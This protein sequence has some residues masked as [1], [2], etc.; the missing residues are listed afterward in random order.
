MADGPPPK[1]PA[2][3]SPA[4][5]LVSWASRAAILS[6]AAAFTMPNP[7]SVLYP[8]CGRCHVLP[9]MA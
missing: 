9:V 5:A 3:A 7:T 1:C 6:A 4:P 2:A 8:P